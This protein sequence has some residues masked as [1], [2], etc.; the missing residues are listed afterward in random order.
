MSKTTQQGSWQF[1]IKQVFCRKTDEHGKPYAAS[2]VITITDG[3]S[4][5]RAINESKQVTTLTE[6]ILKTLKRL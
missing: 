1:E 2:A 6:L 5:C 3:Q 4:T